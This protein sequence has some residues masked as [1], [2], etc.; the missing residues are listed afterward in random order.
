MPDRVLRGLRLVDK[1]NVLA[2]QLVLKLALD[3][4]EILAE[5]D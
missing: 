5:L 2:G 4:F 1:I 3:V